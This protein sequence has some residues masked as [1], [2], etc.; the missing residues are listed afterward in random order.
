MTGIAD[1]VSMDATTKRNVEQWLH[2]QYDEETKIAIRELLNSNS[3]EIIDAFY[4]NL[5]FGTGGLRGIMGVGSNRMNIYTVRAATQGLANYLNRCYPSGSNSVMI[6][7]DSRINSRKFAEESAQVLAANGIQVYLLNELRPVPLISFGCRYKHCQAAIIITASHNPPQYNGYK[8]YWNDGGQVLPP[9][10]QGIIDEVNKITDNRMI[11]TTSLNDPLIVKM[12]KEVDDAFLEALDT[13]QLCPDDNKKQGHLLKLIYT[14]LH[15]TGITL[16]PEVL[17]RWGFTTLAY[18]EKQKP[19]NGHFPTVK[20]PNPEDPAALK[21]GTELLLETQSDILLATDPDCDRV[22]VVVNH[23]NNPIILTGN[24][25]GCLCLEHICQM[26][27]SS[28]RMPPKP[29]VIKSI[30]TT[31]LFKAIAD[32][33]H[34]ACFDVLTGFKYIAE[35]I[36]EWETQKEGYQFIF[37]A[38]ESF[39]YLLGTHSRDKDGV[40][41]CALI[42]EVAL[43]AKLKD[44][45]LIDKLYD[46]YKK[47]GVYRELLTTI[48]FEDSKAGQDQMKAAMKQMRENP[49]RSILG[50]AVVSIADYLTSTITHPQDEKKESLKISKSDVLK[51]LLEDKTTIFIRPSGTEAKVKLYCGVYNAKPATIEEGIEHCDTLARDYSETLRIYLQP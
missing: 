29:A 5:T 32:F 8:V 46:L 43:Q 39:G 34:V 21:M 37:G 28:K 51:L 30:V 9:H 4:K 24:E 36:R 26:L 1:R 44:K 45:T 33:Y 31:E 18:V 48:N 7:Y 38:E 20:V 14:N 40:I 42:A 19:T 47:Y 10:D 41:S 2:G 35:K 11:K 49:P 16:V 12:G 15:G 22:G 13:L 50:T 25:I 6:G 27:T 3:K 17:K 23:K